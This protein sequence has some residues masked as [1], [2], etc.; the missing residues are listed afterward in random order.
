MTFEDD[1]TTFDID[2]GR[3]TFTVDNNFNGT[4][5]LDIYGL[6]SSGSNAQAKISVSKLGNAA[7][8]IIGSDQIDIKPSQ[9]DLGPLTSDPKKVSLYITDSK[10]AGTFNGQIF[11]L[12]GQSLASVPIKVSTVPLLEI[13]VLWVVVGIAAALAFWEIIR[14]LEKLELGVQMKV[15]TGKASERRMLYNQ[16][17]P[18]GV[19]ATPAAMAAYSKNKNKLED[20]IQAD[21]KA[22]ANIETKSQISKFKADI[23][24]L[25]N[26]NWNFGCSDSHCSY[27]VV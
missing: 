4:H 22:A 24:N 5:F 9:I 11:I 10:E 20:E 14:Y 15:V 2:N 27:S 7:G 13:A 1:L 6:S 19:R 8:V 21:L 17:P 16:P 25:T 3:M 12:S 23:E 26:S 18:Q